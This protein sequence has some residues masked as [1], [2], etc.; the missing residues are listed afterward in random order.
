LTLGGISRVED[1]RMLMILADMGADLPETE[2]KRFA[3]K[4]VNDIM[5]TL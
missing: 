1:I 4:A 3:A 5:R 2:R